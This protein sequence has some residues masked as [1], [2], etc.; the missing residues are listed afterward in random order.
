MIGIV[1]FGSINSG[2]TSKTDVEHITYL[3]RRSGWLGFFFAM[4]VTL[5]GVFIFTSRLDAVLAARGDLDAAPF[6][7]TSFNLPYAENDTSH[8]NSRLGS[9]GA[10]TQKKIVL[11]RMISFVRSI[12]SGWHSLMMYVTGWLEVWTGPKDDKQIAWTLGIGWACCGGGLAGGCLVFAKATYVSFAERFSHRNLTCT[13]SVKLL[14]GSL[15]KQNP[16]NQFGHAAP[17]FTIILLVTTAVMQIICLNRGLRVYDSTLVVPVFY[18]VYTAIGFLDSL[19]RHLHVSSGLSLI[20]IP[21]EQIF[22]DEVDSY[23]S[24]TLF[25]IFASI[26]I[27]VSGVVLLTHK[28]PEPVS[29]T[30][31]A[32]LAPVPPGR[33]RKR[34]TPKSGEEDMEGGEHDALWTVGDD[35]GDEDAQELGVV[36]YG[37]EDVDHHQNPIEF[38]YK[39]RGVLSEGGVRG[40]GKVPVHKGSGEEGVGLI[41]PDGD[42]DGDE[43]Q[44]MDRYRHKPAAHVQNSRSNSGSSSGSSSGLTLT[45]PFR[46]DVGEEAFG[47]WSEMKE[48][49][50]R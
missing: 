45:D 36:E 19:V 8:G 10:K 47:T 31:A 21:P 15:S 50:R 22:N 27:L 5:T 32:T 37:D 38:R 9:E 30:P 29:P 24:W 6:S 39:H 14:S 33:K 13:S 18:G 1:A 23:Q 17:I 11:Q 41:G 35:S 42:E 12:A 26:L 44:V 16:G 2:L 28:K 20:N 40:K 25:L 7:A 3:W 48:T 49:G 34:K 43:E 4:S 46:D